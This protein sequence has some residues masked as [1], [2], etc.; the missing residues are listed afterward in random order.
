M[1]GGLD[2]VASARLEPGA[3]YTAYH[4]SNPCCTHVVY[5]LHDTIGYVYVCVSLFQKPA[6][7]F[8]HTIMLLHVTKNV[9]IH[10]V[11]YVCTLL[12][13]STTEFILLHEFCEIKHS[14]H[15]SFKRRP[16]SILREDKDDG[17]VAGTPYRDK[18]KPI[19]EI[20]SGKRRDGRHSYSRLTVFAGNYS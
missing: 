7:E 1:N 17:N 13:R 16:L 20:Q 10:N 12:H 14:S 11:V 19:D 9:Y 18:N 4:G 5:S 3:G 15:C 6:H 2:S 8:V